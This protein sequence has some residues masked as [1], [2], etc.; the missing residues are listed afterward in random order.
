M[1]LSKLDSNRLEKS[2]KGFCDFLESQVKNEF[3]EPNLNKT[4]YNF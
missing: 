3:L 2:F 4:N 1:S